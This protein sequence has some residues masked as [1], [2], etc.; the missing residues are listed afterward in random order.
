VFSRSESLYGEEEQMKRLSQKLAAITK[1]GDEN[2]LIAA[3][4]LIIR[5]KTM[6]RRWNIGRLDRFLKQ[7]QKDLFF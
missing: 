2:A 1:T 5:L 3:K 6:N 4:D 7:R